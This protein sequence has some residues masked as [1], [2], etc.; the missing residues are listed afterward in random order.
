MSVFLIILKILSVLAILIIIFGVLTS[1]LSFYLCYRIKNNATFIFLSYLSLASIFT[2]YKFP[3]NGIMSTLFKVDYLHINVYECKIG[4]FL[5]YTSLE[6]C[7]WI[8]VLISVEQYLCVKVQHWRTIH[9]KP[10]RAYITVSC[11]VLFFI[12]LNFNIFFTFGFEV[13]YPIEVIKNSTEF[14]ITQNFTIE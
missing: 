6:T 11:L 3:M 1:L 5:Q 13:D 8:L 7:A 12:A 14:N 9:F 10:K 4:I 2:L